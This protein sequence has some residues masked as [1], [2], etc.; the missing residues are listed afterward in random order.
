MKAKAISIPVARNS[1][2]S[3]PMRAIWML[4]A[5]VMLLMLQTVMG[6]ARSAPESFADLDR[7]SVV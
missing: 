5:A 3:A 7:K 2:D 4:T 6:H 1:T